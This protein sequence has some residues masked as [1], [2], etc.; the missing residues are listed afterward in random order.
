MIELDG[1]RKDL[2][3]QLSTSPAPDPIRIHPGIAKTYRTRIG[4]LIAGLSE[5]ERMGEAKEA[6]WGCR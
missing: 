1:R 6:L 4:Q 2:E 3:R 5:A